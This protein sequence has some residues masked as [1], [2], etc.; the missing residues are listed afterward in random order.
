MRMYMILLVD[1]IGL[2]VAPP[3]IATYPGTDDELAA[4]LAGVFSDD[5]DVHSALIGLMSDDPDEIADAILAASD[6]FGD[7]DECACLS[8]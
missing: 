5:P 1:A 3:F 7:G 6:P 4:D 2:P 8:V